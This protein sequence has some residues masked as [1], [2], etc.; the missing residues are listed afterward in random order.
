MWEDWGMKSGSFSL[1]FYLG[2]VMLLFGS[3]LIGGAKQKQPTLDQSFQ[4]AP[5][6]TV[7]VENSTG[8]VQIHTWDETYVRVVAEK[9]SPPGQPVYFSDITFAAS[10]STI[11][12]GCNPTDP[13]AHIQLTLYVPHQCHVE[14][15]KGQAAARAPQP[16]APNQPAANQPQPAASSGTSSRIAGDRSRGADQTKEGWGPIRRGGDR[17]DSAE[18]TMGVGVRV[19]PPLGS[20]S[21]SSSTGRGHSSDRDPFAV[22]DQDPFF[23]SDRNPVGRSKR[24]STSSTDMGLPGSDRDR[25][26][27]HRSAPVLKPR[28]ESGSS[29]TNA[30]SRNNPPEP[31]RASDEGLVLE[32]DLVNLSA[33]VRDRSG[34]AMTGL[35]QSSFQV[36]EDDVLQ[37]IAFF[38][39]TSAP[40]NLVLML[41][42]SGSTREKL[43]D[44]KQAAMRFLDAISPEDHVAV[45]TFTR[46]VK[47]VSPLTKDRRQL[48]ERIEQIQT[49]NGGTALYEAVWRVLAEVLEGTRGQRNA[50]VLLTDGVDN[51][52]SETNVI[53]SVVDF[54][55]LVNRIEESDVIV[56][57]IYMDTEQEV[58]FKYLA[59]SRE[60]YALAR[61]R[62]QALAEVTGGM[63]FRAERAKDLEKTY[64]QVASE[65]RITY[66]LGYYPSNH[67]RDGSWRR[68][69]VRIKSRNAVVRTRTGYFAR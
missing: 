67:Q 62:L 49:A 30:V 46:E 39:P 28:H 29:D 45:V 42:L 58:V 23:K 48:R 10:E 19:I 53:P 59:E 20:D 51:S 17:K 5:G 13:Q 41:D 31:R 11:V 32:G 60:T 9:V 64:D 27:P 24:E 37:Q 55:D 21:D 50:I 38:S 65:L 66:S 44:I 43:Q 56:Y 1:R 6:G 2:T 63:M 68:V 25:S 57:P 12:I 69:L 4:L 52:I 15:G 33:T 35:T 22:F 61:E 26:S 7:E 18:G 8:D 3:L 40:F 36:Y 16:V 14:I 34:K 47:V 54:D